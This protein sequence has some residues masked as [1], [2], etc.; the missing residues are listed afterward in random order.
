MTALPLL[1]NN[2]LLRIAQGTAPEIYQVGDSKRPGFMHDA[3]AD[4][5]SIGMSI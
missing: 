5:C 1:P 3:I 4:G 2:D